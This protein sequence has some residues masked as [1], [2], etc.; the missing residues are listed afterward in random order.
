MKK[1]DA[2]IYIAP[3]KRMISIAQSN[4]WLDYN[5]FSSYHIPVQRKDCEYLVM[6]EVEAIIN[7]VFTRRKK[8]YELIRD[9][10]IFCVFTGVSYVDL[11]CLTK[12]NLKKF[13]DGLWLCFERHKTGVMCNIPLLQILLDIITKYQNKNKTGALFPAATYSTL[14]IGLKTIAKMCGIK[15]IS[16]G[17][18]LDM[19]VPVI[20]WNKD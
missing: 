18:Q 13:D 11:E 8:L 3:L 14:S 16:L 12:G 10:F 6:S 17:I 20:G 9:L 2:H 7:V 5:P 15:N 4:G 19:H 1:S